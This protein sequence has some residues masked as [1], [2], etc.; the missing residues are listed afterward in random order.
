M[1][2]TERNVF[3]TEGFPPLRT[4]VFG[5]NTDYNASGRTLACPKTFV[6]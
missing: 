5:G 2:G 4:Y 6:A 3:K 1:N